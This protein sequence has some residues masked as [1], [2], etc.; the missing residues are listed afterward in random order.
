MVVQRSILTYRSSI[1]LSSADGLVFLGLRMRDVRNGMSVNEIN[2]ENRIATDMVI[3]TDESHT[4]NASLAEPNTIG[5]NT[6]TDVS[7]AATTAV[8][9][10]RVPTIEAL[11]LS[12]PFD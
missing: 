8:A 10:S 6:M 9:T 4:N 11:Q 12:S 7:V 1:L 3:P 2:S 5:A